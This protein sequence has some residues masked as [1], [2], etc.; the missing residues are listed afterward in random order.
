[1]GLPDII[2]SPIVMKTK[3]VQAI[4]AAFLLFTA[5]CPVT[6]AAQPNMPRE[7]AEAPEYSR[8][9]IAA[10]DFAIHAQQRVMRADKELT[11]LELVAIVR[12]EQ[13]V[14]AGMNYRLMLK[15]KVDGEEKTAES[16]VWWQAWRKPDPYQMT[17]W[18]WK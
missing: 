17:S 2:R 13:Q 3:R 16:V 14:V 12:A 6:G 1:M 11:K 8:E 7:N 5:A 15:V 18:D 9:V 4:L 10:A